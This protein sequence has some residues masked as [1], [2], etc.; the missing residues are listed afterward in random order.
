MENL[1]KL[2]L[3]RAALKARKAKLAKDG[4]DLDDKIREARRRQNEKLAK[5]IGHAMIERSADPRCRA[6]L[7]LIAPEIKSP[8]YRSLIEQVI[9]AGKRPQEDAAETSSPA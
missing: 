6:A 9:A 4:Q 1:T 7:G 3:Q 5:T 8:T 2:H